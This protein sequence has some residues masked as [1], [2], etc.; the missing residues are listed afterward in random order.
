MDASTSETVARRPDKQRPEPLGK[1]YY[2]VLTATV[3]S[4]LGDGVDQIGYP[5][6]ASA[7]TRNPLLIALVAVAQRLPW[8]VFTLPAGVITDRVDRRKAIVVMDVIR[9][10]ITVAVAIAVLGFGSQLPKPSAIATVVGTRTGMYSILLFASLLLGFAEVLRDNA[11]QTIVPSIVSKAN[12]ERANGRQMS[13][14]M[15]ANTF[16]GPPLGSL[17]IAASFFLPFAVDA[18]SFFFAAGLVFVIAGEFRAKQRPVSA[19]AAAASASGSPTAPTPS[20]KDDLKEGVRWLWSHPLLRPMAIILGIMNGIGA[21]Q[22]STLVLFAQEVLKTT[23][24]EFAILTMGGA[25]GGILGATT[26]P[27]ISRRLGSGPSLWLALIAG[28]VLPLII[29]ATSSWPVVF[30]VFLVM[31]MV[32]I[33]WNVITV[34]LRQ[35]IIP[36]HLLGRVNS[37]YRFFA[38]GMMP[39]GTALGGVVVTVVQPWKGRETALRAPWFAAA[40]IGA[41]LTVYAIPRLTT[42]KMDAARAAAAHD[43]AEERPAID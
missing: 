22:L 1:N 26:A 33:V 8:L 30:V 42:E 24:I 35:S 14:E 36:D 40:A 27:R 32:G 19:L 28:A 39:V 17:M 43:A 5:W 11:A 7:V 18:V 4:S 9:G 10:C 31:T 15:V 21:M 34:S 2:R 41:L 37:V 12:L 20:W 6:L 29:G 38:W 3:V 13:A 16:I 23:P 25:V